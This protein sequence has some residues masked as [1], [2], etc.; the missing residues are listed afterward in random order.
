MGFGEQTIGYRV[1]A[2]CI[3]ALRGADARSW[4]NAQTSND[5]GLLT[6]GVLLPSL[7]LN[8]KGRVLAFL[9]I[10]EHEGRLCFSTAADHWPK[11]R[12]NFER[13]IFMEEV[14]LNEQAWGFVTLVGEGVEEGISRLKGEGLGCFRSERLGPTIDL[15]APDK[16]RVGE[17]LGELASRLGRSLCPIDD[18]EWEKMRVARGVPAFGVDFGDWTYPQEVGLKRM[19]SFSKG[20]Y[21]GQEVV[22]MLEH[23][24][25]PSRLLVR[26]EGAD[27][28]GRGDALF[29]QGEKV[30]ETTSVAGGKALALVK[31]SCA[32][33]GVALHSPRG[34]VM[35]K[36]RVE[37]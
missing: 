14:E 23:R 34:L 31:A 22:Y 26:L 3:V 29:W 4:L 7:V 32:Q 1:Q 21:L 12:D 8:S 2:E 27:G 30:G 6:Q 11:L 33:E 5:L 10:F 17:H 28:L 20:C 13:H 25:R 16:E 24:G 18:G 19:L 15:L 9:W 37:W 36:E 35:V